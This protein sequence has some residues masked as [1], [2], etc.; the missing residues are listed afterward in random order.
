MPWRRWCGVP[1]A[2]IE[3]IDQAVEPPSFGFFSSS[4]TLA[5]WLRAAIAAASPVPPPPTTT[6]S[7]ARSL[8]AP[9]AAWP[10]EVPAILP[11]T[12]PDI[13]PVPPG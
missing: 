1:V 7:A 3:P 8:I 2:V 10:A 13:R 9:P 4:S 12:E 6:T 5:P 11:N